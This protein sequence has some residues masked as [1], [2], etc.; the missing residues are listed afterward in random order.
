MHSKRAA[1]TLLEFIVSFGIIALVAGLTAYTIRASGP[2]LTLRAAARALAADLRQA[3]ELASSAQIIHEVRFN[4]ADGSYTLTR[5]GA[6][7]TTVKIVTLNATL[8]FDAITI[9]NDTAVFNTLGATGTPGNIVLINRN[10]QRS[11]VQLRP[12]GYVRIQ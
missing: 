3:S 1:F 8:N 9:A 11:T 12:S 5:A 6:P 7:E 10:N 2:S 4:A